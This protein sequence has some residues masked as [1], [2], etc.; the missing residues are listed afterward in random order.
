MV[1]VYIYVYVY[2]TESYLSHGI[3]IK[4]LLMFFPRPLITK[5]AKSWKL[6]SIFKFGKFQVGQIDF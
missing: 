4:E 6:G 1:C 2:H 5:P 3:P